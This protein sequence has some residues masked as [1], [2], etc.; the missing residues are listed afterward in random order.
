M[1]IDPETYRRQLQMM[2]LQTDTSPVA[3]WSQGAAR[4]ADGLSTALLLKRE[5]DADESS[6]ANTQKVFSTLFGG[7]TPTAAPVTTSAEPLPSTPAPMPNRVYSQDE[8]NPIDA[9]I[10]T[11]KQLAYG[12]NAPA[13]YAPAIGKAAIE[14]DLPP[15]LLAAQLRQ[16]SGFKP[17]AVSSA[18]AAGISQFMPDTAREMGINPLDPNQ[19]IPAGARYLRQN[20]DKFGSVENGLAAY[21]WGPGNV[22]KWVANGADP[23]RLPAETQNYIKSIGANAQVASVNPNYVPAPAPT[24]GV[25]DRAT[26]PQGAP[27]PTGMDPQRAAAMMSILMDR[28]ADPAAKQMVATLMQSQLNQ[29]VKQVDLG[30]R[31]ANVDKMGRMISVI[32]KSEKPTF[33]TYEKDEFGRERKGFVDPYK[34]TITDPLSGSSYGPGGTGAA[35]PS[36]NG[37]VRNADGSMTINGVNIPAGTDPKVARELITKNTI[38]NVLPATSEETGKVRHEIRQLPSYKNF[39]EAMP[40]YRNM[41]KTIGTNSKASD[42]N[43]VYSLGKIF[44]PGSV[45][46]EGEM[47]MV[48]NTG[49]LP[50][51]LVG[52]INSL[53]GGAALTPETRDAIMME[54]QNRIQSYRQGFEQD[55]GHYRG[56]AKRNRMDERDIIPDFGELTPYVPRTKKAETAPGWQEIAPN[57][58]IR[59]KK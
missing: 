45:V 24:G 15:N 5:L 30:D 16:E 19:A 35:P 22:Q 33:E 59:E 50:D 17:T 42:L 53:N 26:I 20:I 8:V 9:Q 14:N 2:L 56:I 46:R 49:S 18:G 10:L 1:P 27:T 41:E 4:M 29:E 43:L 51:W 36:P 12:V 11:P 54:A 13:Q 37:V 57:V 40:I 25:P 55:A 31:I 39:A 34:R 44:D 48:K 6:R 58:R 38:T 7:A 23:S 28:R 47:V 21:N 3:H 52:S 32:P